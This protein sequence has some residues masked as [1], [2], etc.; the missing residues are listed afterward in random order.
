MQVVEGALVVSSDSCAAGVGDGIY[1]ASY[2]ASLPGEETTS[3][4]PSEV[5]HAPATHL[6]L[7]AITAATL[8][9]T[10]RS[11]A[12]SLAAGILAAISAQGVDPESC[13]VVMEVEIH[14]PGAASTDEYMPSQKPGTIGHCSA[15]PANPECPTPFP[16]FPA[17]TEKSPT[18]DVAIVG[19][20]TGG[21]Y[22]ALRLVDIGKVQGSGICI[23]E[24]TNRVGG[25][26]ITVRGLGPNKDLNVDAGGYRTWP[27]YTPVT[28]ALITEYLKL[29]VTCYE[30]EE[31]CTKWNIADAQGHKIGFATMPERLMERLVEAGARW[32]PGHELASFDASATTSAG[33]TVILSFKNGASATASS[34]IL[35]IP[36][37]PLL[38]TIRSSTFPAGG[39]PGVLTYTALHSVQTEIVSKLYLYYKKAWWYDLGFKQGDFVF[40]GDATQ[41]PLKGRYHDGDVRCTLV[42]KEETQC[43]GFLLAT[44]IHDFGGETE[45]YSSHQNVKDVAVSSLLDPGNQN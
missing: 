29:D 5:S 42:N 3:K 45:M 32:F 18:C 16:T 19:G 31:P 11:P 37:R 14:A 24:A 25:R 12:L 13:D 33:G 7:L 41:M 26:L 21:L 23:F 44:Y 35:N 30:N 1:G 8:A 40:E 10:K 38:N 27:K 6:S 22:T 15:D 17:S 28:H 2:G 39:A 36:Q 43:H 4:P 9:S 20:G 34:T